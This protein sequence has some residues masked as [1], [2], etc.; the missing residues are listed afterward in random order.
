MTDNAVTIVTHLRLLVS[1]FVPYEH[2]DS[3]LPLCTQ[4]ISSNISSPC[5]TSIHALQELIVRRLQKA[6]LTSQIPPFRALIRRF[7]GSRSFTSHFSILYLLFSL[8]EIE[9]TPSFFSSSLSL[10]SCQP[11]PQ[12]QPQHKPQPQPQPSSP[13]DGLSTSPLLPDDQLVKAAIHAMQGI[14]TPRIVHFV[15][16]RL[17][18][19]RTLSIDVYSAFSLFCKLGTL[20]LKIESSLE[21]PITGRI[22]SSISSFLRHIITRHRQDIS[23][24][25]LQPDLTLNKV[26][27]WSKQSEQTLSNACVVSSL[28]QQGSIG[29]KLVSELFKLSRHG[30]VAYASICQQ[31]FVA[32]LKPLLELI[33]IWVADGELEKINPSNGDTVFELW[34]TSS[35][36]NSQT[37]KEFWSDCFFVVQDQI[38]CFLPIEFANKIFKVGKAVS[39][40]RKFCNDPE[41]LVNTSSIQSSQVI[42]DLSQGDCRSLCRSINHAF[43]AANQ[44]LLEL[45]CTRFSLRLHLDAIKRYLLLVQGDFAMSLIESLGN[46]LV[47]RNLDLLRHNLL[48]QLDNAIRSSNV[49]HDDVITRDCLDIRTPD[50]AH[51]NRDFFTLE[52]RIDSNSPISVVLSRNVID[53][54]LKC[55]NFI[56]KIKKGSVALGMIWDLFTAL[57]KRSL[58]KICGDLLHLIYI[59]RLELVNFVSTLEHHVFFAVIEDSFK[60]LED[61]LKHSTSLDDVI[62]AHNSF[63]N[64]LIC[65]NFIGDDVAS[66]EVS[67]ILT[68]IFDLIGKFK[69]VLDQLSHELE[70][71]SFSLV[72]IKSKL[73]ANFVQEDFYNVDELNLKKQQIESEMNIISH[74]CSHCV[75]NLQKEFRQQLF[76]LIEA[77]KKISDQSLK[78]LI[79]SFNFNDYY[80]ESCDEPLYK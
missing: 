64:Q 39:F 48:S 1:Q 47:V 13:K 3:T 23:D 32:S 56:W 59:F 38:P 40:V 11:Q 22:A 12:P 33:S 72:D 29:S 74:K 69:L 37:A 50:D 14:S 28:L 70:S 68:S 36:H 30:D 78:F 62:I 80:K 54:Y 6:N 58:P 76:I 75:L 20:L 5:V 8:S 2:V 27:I 4:I 10:F 16:E 66:Q 60:V 61:K 44:R 71:N 45:V 21:Q 42:N 65:R 25:L 73:Q 79:S 35:G 34:I 63:I 18:P 15:E 17:L 53:Q 24:L 46:S 55:F 49:C 7:Q 43:E 51:S 52:Y 31:S 57:K 19:E 77:L 9:E 26:F 41:F 67:S